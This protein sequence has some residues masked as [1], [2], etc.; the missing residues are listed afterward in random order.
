MR[1][2]GIGDTLADQIEKGLKRQKSSAGERADE[3]QSR[4]VRQ[5]VM[6]QPCGRH[7]ASKADS[8]G[9]CRYFSRFAPRYAARSVVECRLQRAFGRL[10]RH[11]HPIA[12]EGRNHA[13]CI[14]NAKGR[15]ALKT[16]L[17]SRNSAETR[18][19]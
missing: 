13:G 3:L 9:C 14:A 15:A 6:Q 4:S 10:K 12:G 19:C 8:L 17:K 5:A 18:L 1:W 16:W 2:Q 7:A 11:A